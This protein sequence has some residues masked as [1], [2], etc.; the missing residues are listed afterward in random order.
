MHR[1]DPQQRLGQYPRFGAVYLQLSRL[2]LGWFFFFFLL[3]FNAA[4]P[5]PSPQ[6]HPHVLSRAQ[7]PLCTAVKANHAS[8]TNELSLVTCHCEVPVTNAANPSVPAGLQ[9]VPRSPLSPAAALRPPARARP[10]SPPGPFLLRSH[11]W[12]GFPPAGVP[13]GCGNSLIFGRCCHTRRRRQRAGIE[14]GRRSAPAREGM[15]GV[16]VPA[17]PR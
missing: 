7:P 6:R 9:P 16:S 11:P 14:R 10:F 15:V 3:H 2:K 17:G 5:S 1:H 4:P 8:N 13:E 12:L